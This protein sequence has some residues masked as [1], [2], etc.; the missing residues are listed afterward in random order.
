MGGLGAYAGVG[1]QVGGGYTDGAPASGTAQGIYGE[2]DMGGGPSASISGQIDFGGN[3][4]GTGSAPVPVM[5]GIGYG[6]AVG[7]GVFQSTTYV[8]PSVGSMLAP[9][10]NLFTPPTQCSH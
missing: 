1:V 8:S 10:R 3:P 4:S 7:A 9:I 5:P 2:A 6:V